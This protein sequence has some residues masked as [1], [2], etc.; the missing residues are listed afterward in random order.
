[1]RSLTLPWSV[2]NINP[3]LVQWQ[4]F[5]RFI[6]C[7]GVFTKYFFQNLKMSLDNSGWLFSVYLPNRESPSCS[8]SDTTD[9]LSLPSDDKRPRLRLSPRPGCRET[10]SKPSS[11][12][13]WTETWSLSS[14]LSRGITRPPEV[15][16]LPVFS[17]LHS[18]EV[19]L[20]T[21]FFDLRKMES[22]FWAENKLYSLSN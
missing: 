11:W 6:F 15:S 22:E 9:Y 19:P 10:A 3:S 21:L 13:E 17:G 2:N 4:P 8:P 14:P 5:W 16:F 7:L 20:S 12:S 1:M 18:P